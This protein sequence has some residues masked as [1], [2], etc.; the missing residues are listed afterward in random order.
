MVE[1]ERLIPLSLR[2]KKGTV[3]N[4]KTVAH[5][6][7][8]QYTRALDLKVLLF[9]AFYRFYGNVATVIA[10]TASFN[11]IKMPLSRNGTMQAPFSDS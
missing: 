10:S 7:P 11:S 2:R 5:M 9:F 1:G 4:E 6:T 8:D 3:K